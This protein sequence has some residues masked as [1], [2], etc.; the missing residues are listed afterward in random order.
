MSETSTSTVIADAKESSPPSHQLLGSIGSLTLSKRESSIIS[1]TYKEAS[2]LYL[3]R[4]PSEAISVLEPII[5]RNQAE[6]N[7]HDDDQVI[8]SALIASASRKSRIMIWNLYLSIL[9][10]IIELGPDEGE[11]TLGGKDW[12]RLAAKVR[13]G[14]IWDEVVEI[15]YGGIEANVDADVV[16]NLF[17]PNREDDLEMYS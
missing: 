15:G 2:K 14:T 12:R 6:G 1:R 9:N 17:V 11:A 3:T 10:A 5:S 7:F 16:A 13:D 8:G 4:R